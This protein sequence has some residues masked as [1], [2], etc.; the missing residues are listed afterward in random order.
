MRVA[1]VLLLIAAF[2]FS[3]CQTSETDK[4]LAFGA[5]L[6]DSVEE[7]ETERKETVKA[8]DQ[9]EEITRKLDVAKS[10]EDVADASRQWEKNVSGLAE[11]VGKVTDRFKR[12][13]D[14]TSKFFDE[15]DEIA[16]GATNPT[17]RASLEERNRVLRIQWE[18]AFRD[19][20]ESV[21]KLSNLATDSDDVGRI[22]RSAALRQSLLRNIEELKSIAKEARATLGELSKLTAQGRQLA[23]FG[24][25]S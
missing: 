23:D 14:Q 15:L 6:K 12:V 10:P 5:E 9:S 16:R 24:G 25:G 13:G 22:L 3:A 19:A 11:R 21:G 17:V 20:A 1:G 18:A 7:F 4:A 8:I 2:A